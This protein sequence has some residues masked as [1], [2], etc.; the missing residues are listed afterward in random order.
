M[1]LDVSKFSPSLERLV[2][3]IAKLPGLGRKSA[4]R[5]ALHILRQ[6]EDEARELAQA[7]LDVRS[8]IH[9]CRICSNFTEDDVCSICSDARRDH[10]LICVVE[11]PGDVLRLERTGSFRGVYHVLG[12][13]LSP[14]DDIGPDDL[15]IAE[16]LERVKI[17]GVREVILATNPTTEGDATALY[18]SPALKEHGVAVSRIARGVPVGAELEQVDEVTLASALESRT[19][20]S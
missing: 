1:V 6:P 18:L 5:L 13:T 16:L 17:G 11:T 15:R 20:M 9:L 7:I 8:K 14:L 3:R 2:E 4:A 19:R 10:G 12:G